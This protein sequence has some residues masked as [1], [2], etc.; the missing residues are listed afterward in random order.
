MELPLAFLTIFLT[1]IT[2]AT[3]II[4]NVTLNTHENCI[5]SDSWPLQSNWYE[6]VLISWEVNAISR[7]CWTVANIQH[8]VMP[9]TFKTP[10][11][12]SEDSDT[13]RWPW[14]YLGGT[15]D[16]ALSE[17]ERVGVKRTG[18]FS[19]GFPRYQAARSDGGK[20]V[21]VLL[22]TA[23]NYSL[24]KADLIAS[25]FC[26]HQKGRLSE[27]SLRPLHTEAQCLAGSLYH[28]SQGLC[29]AVQ[30]AGMS[31][32]IGTGYLGG[33]DRVEQRRSCFMLTP[34]LSSAPVSNWRHAY[35]EFLGQDQ[36]EE[37]PGVVTDVYYT[38]QAMRR[39]G[40][41]FSVN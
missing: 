30:M 25:H 8:K 39:Q 6:D 13:T 2:L 34:W 1:S 18:S 17:R 33:T 16:S 28:Q 29:G 21:H 23:P 3:V 40:L 24:N 22:S 15:S 9:L 12:F 11:G 36:S 26:L 27:A 38:L 32:R 14:L 41:R 35:W 5:N 37:E 7:K 4:S 20:S 10:C 31:P 19:R